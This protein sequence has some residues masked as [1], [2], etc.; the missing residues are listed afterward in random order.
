MTTQEQIRQ[1]GARIVFE[2]EIFGKKH[3]DKTA[4]PNA[5]A[6]DFIKR[7]VT[8]L[9]EFNTLEQFDV[10]SLNLFS[11]AFMYAY[12]KGAEIALFSR[13]GN[14]IAKIN[15]EFDK[16]MQGIC[17][18]KL[19][20]HLRLC[21]NKKSSAMLDMY[22]QMFQHMRGSTEKMIEEKITFDDCI[23]TILNGAF[24][25]GS[26][27]SLTTELTEEDLLIKYQEESDTPYNYDTYDQKY[28]LDGFK[29]VY[30]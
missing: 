12:G 7:M 11:R 2:N 24:F 22:F 6:E 27:I 17:G 5:L 14:S 15:Y 13:L 21:V 30:C 25:Y 20:D 26:E 3:I 9:L 4:L 29:M 19:S 16:A 18:E 8:D 28:K 10:T 1:T 23:S